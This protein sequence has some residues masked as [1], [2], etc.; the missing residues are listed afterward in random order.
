MN[1]LTVRWETEEFLV[2]RLRQSGVNL[3][4]GLSPPS[5]RSQS[6]LG[7]NQSGFVSDGPRPEAT[8]YLDPWPNSL[9]S[10]PGFTMVH[11]LVVVLEVRR[12]KG[13]RHLYYMIGVW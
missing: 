5:I 9:L 2:S 10:R 6:S 7:D 11:P 12:R 13:S 3:I 1:P 8:A 4:V